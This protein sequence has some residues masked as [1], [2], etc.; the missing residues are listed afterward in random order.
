MGTGVGTSCTGG[1]LGTEM[2]W[3]RTV[4]GTPDGV[5]GRVWPA[6]FISGTSGM[7]GIS[8]ICFNAR[9]WDLGPESWISLR[10]AVVFIVPVGD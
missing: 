10:A 3:M 1:M 7:G 4:A 9:L 6:T 8:P 2:G 5:N